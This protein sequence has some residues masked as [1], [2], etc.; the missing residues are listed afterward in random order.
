MVSMISRAIVDSTIESL[1]KAIQSSLKGSP[2]SD[3]FAWRIL[4]EVTYLS[5]RTTPKSDEVAYGGFPHLAC[6]GFHLAVGNPPFED[7]EEIFLAGLKRLH[8]RS[9]IQ[10]KSLAFSLDDI[11]ILGV[12][13][14]VVSIGSCLDT[15]RAW[16]TTIIDSSPQRTLWTARIR[17]VAGDLLDNRGRLRVLPNLTD[18]DAVGLELVLRRKWPSLFSD[19]PQLDGETQYN[20]LLHLLK[21]SPLQGDLE[22][23]TIRLEA[24][25]T[26]IDYAGQSLYPKLSDTVKILED[27]RHSFKR[28][29]WEEEPPRG[30]SPARWLIDNEYH[31]QSLLWT[32]LYPIYGSDLVDETYLPNWGQK[33]PRADL[34]I[35]KLKLIIEV[36]YARTQADFAKIE[37]QVAGDLGLYFKDTKIY[38]RMIVFVYDDCDQDYPERYDG[39]RNALA[40]RERIEEVVIVRRPSM[41]PG[42]NSR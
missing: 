29:V 3:S 13:E 23:A 24:L 8:E 17:H 42:R 41:L 40:Q 27:I 21:T 11:A 30:R 39:L 19:V 16:L 37:E 20:L 33:Q 2:H 9:E 31:V 36:K 1:E 14:G 15:E 35:I 4:G 18:P 6:L 12:V 25:E 7:A 32:V 10:S 34:G 22:R 28:W 38:D 5:N 26:L